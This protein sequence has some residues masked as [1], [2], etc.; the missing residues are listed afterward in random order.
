M[1]GPGTSP[2]VSRRG[3]RSTTPWAPTR[4]AV[5]A[6]ALLCLVGA[7]LIFAGIALVERGREPRFAPG[8]PADVIEAARLATPPLDAGPEWRVVAAIDSPFGRTVRLR[9]YLDSVEVRGADCVLHLHGRAGAGSGAGSGRGSG[10]EADAGGRTGGSDD[11]PHPSSIRRE[12]SP[13]S[14]DWNEIARSLGNRPRATGDLLQTVLPETHA[15]ALR[16]ALRADPVVY[17]SLPEHRGESWTL[18]VEVS[19]DINDSL[20][21]RSLEALPWVGPSDQHPDPAGSDRNPDDC[22]G[23]GGSHRNADLS[24]GPVDLLLTLD[25]ASLAIL[26]VRDL[27][28]YAAHGHVGRALVFNP[29]P[30]AYSGRHDLRAGDPVDQY[31]V[32]MDAP[33]LD[34]TGHLRGRWVETATDRPPLAREQSLIFAYP[35]HDPRFVQAMAYV[36]GDRG[37]QRVEDLGFSGLFDRPLR[38]RVYGTTADNSW[39]SRATREVVL[40]SGG[41]NDA[42][43]ADIILHELGHAIHDALVPGFDGGDTYAISEGFSDFWAASLTDGPCIGDWDATSYSPPCLRR[44]DTDAVYPTSLNGRPHNDGLIWSATL[45]DIRHLLGAEAA[46]RLALASF[47]EQGTRTTFPEAAAGLLVAAE[48]LGMQNSVH[49]VRGVLEDRGLL[50]RS[51]HAVL[52]PHDTHHIPLQAPGRILGGWTRSLVITGDGRFLFPQEEHS[53]YSDPFPGGPPCI[54]PLAWE[55]VEEA[56]AMSSVATV[57]G[58]ICATRVELELEWHDGAVPLVRVYAVWELDTG[59]FSWEYRY[60]GADVSGLFCGASPGYLSPGVVQ[61]VSL[62][63]LTAAGLHGLRGFHADLGDTRSPDWLPHLTG[64]RFSLVQDDDGSGLRLQRLASPLAPAKLTLATHPNPFRDA[65]QVRLRLQQDRSAEVSVFDAQG[66]R[67]RRLLRE[68]LRQGAHTIPWDGR[69]DLG[70]PLP[71]AVYWIRAAA[72]EDLGTASVLRLK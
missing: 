28:L 24:T 1:T 69:D 72:G 37:L 8:T 52:E 26:E 30:V 47:L 55:S 65:V 31:R 13:G 29:N 51:L 42:E 20:L 27:R 53:V 33:R 56:A 2:F 66:R 63:G 57:T 54:A 9:P 44:T 18:R 11:P 41:V 21:L 68:E 34:G 39:Y 6:G 10:V 59:S 15:F 3:D 46:E 58:S 62:A 45:W 61:P 67:V 16:E 49:Q 71:S 50:P 40:G 48:R 70:R 22:H 64:A 14:V 17:A 7:L 12:R 36:H 23:R 35:S 25:P 32:W 38:L 5:V 19:L 43:D 60:A 4:R